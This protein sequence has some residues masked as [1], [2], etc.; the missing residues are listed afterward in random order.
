MDRIG[1]KGNLE[2]ER[3]LVIVMGDDH[4]LIS[5]REGGGGPRKAN[6]DVDIA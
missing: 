1:G 3:V 4:V 6:H 2:G 5:Q